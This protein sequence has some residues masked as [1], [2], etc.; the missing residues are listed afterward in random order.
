MWGKCAVLFMMRHVCLASFALRWQMTYRHYCPTMAHCGLARHALL[1][2]S[3]V[4]I[5]VAE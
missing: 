3:Q 2:L 4:S 5:W 1:T